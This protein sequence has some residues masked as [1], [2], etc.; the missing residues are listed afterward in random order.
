MIR[1]D[2]ISLMAFA[3]LTILAPPVF[4]QRQEADWHDKPVNSGPEA[5]PCHGE[6]PFVFQYHSTVSTSASTLSFLGA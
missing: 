6:R 3:V 5:P 1:M 2:I 4:A